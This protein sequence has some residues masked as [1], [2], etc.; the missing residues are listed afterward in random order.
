MASV[1][2]FLWALVQ[3]RQLTGEPTAGRVRTMEGEIYAVVK[4]VGKA[5]IIMVGHGLTL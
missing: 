2:R 5:L 1:S 4:G 3:R